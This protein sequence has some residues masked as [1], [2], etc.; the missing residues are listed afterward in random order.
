MACF[1]IDNS[2]APIEMTAML[3]IS[4]DFYIKLMLHM[5]A[6]RLMITCV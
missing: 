4:N 2:A 1:I 6:D 3:K 5:L